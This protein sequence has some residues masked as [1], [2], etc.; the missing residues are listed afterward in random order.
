M[1]ESVIPKYR[2]P[3][4]IDI[5][6]LSTF[7]YFEFDDTFVDKFEAHEPWELVYIDRGECYVIADDR[8]ILLSQGEMY[9]HKPFERHKLEIVKGVYPN[10]LIITFSTTSRAMRY[11]ENQKLI[12]NL[13]AK[14]HIAAILHEATH[15][16]E[17]PFNVPYSGELEP[18]SS[19]SLWGGEQSI[20]IRLELMLIELVRIN[21]YYV[22]SPRMFH[23]KEIIT[24]DFCLRVIGLMEKHLYDTLTMEELCRS[25]SFS[26]SYVSKRFAGVCG[27]SVMDY[28]NMMKIQEAKRLIRETGKNFQEISES[29]MLSNPHYFSTL[30]K[31][32]VGMTPTQYKKSCKQD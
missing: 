11:F 20:M 16:F 27:Y 12:A 5:K 10:V 4:M 17:R 25:L 14:Q 32:Y 19:D 28:F 31:K 2:M 24:D 26:K 21:R 23:S 8:R 18:K 1:Q 30:F 13:S 6:S 9:F 7:H 3:K 15:T 29:L 22:N